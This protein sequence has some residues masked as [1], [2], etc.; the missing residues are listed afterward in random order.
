MFFRVSKDVRNNDVEGIRLILLG[1]SLY[2]IF[3]EIQ[4]F[5]FNNL[6]TDSINSLHDIFV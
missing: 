2:F 5:N 1:I 4:N 3:I 6:I